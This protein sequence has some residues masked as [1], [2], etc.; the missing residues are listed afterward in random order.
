[1]QDLQGQGKSSRKASTKALS[2]R[3]RYNFDTMAWENITYEQVKAW[4]KLYDGVDVVRI[5]KEDIPQ[6]ID[7]RKGT[8]IVRKKDWKK[9]VCNWLKKEKMKIDGI[10]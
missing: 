7:K 2:T 9:T 6:W 8:K 10:I 5:L 3:I 4:E 1:M